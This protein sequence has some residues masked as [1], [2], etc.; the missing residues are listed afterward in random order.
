MVAWV[1]FISY[2]AILIPIVQTKKRLR[3]AVQA[4]DQGIEKERKKDRET[5]PESSREIIRCR[6]SSH[7]SSPSLIVPEQSQKQCIDTIYGVVSM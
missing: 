5:S 6:S 2:A 4:N 1:D 7:I 3:W